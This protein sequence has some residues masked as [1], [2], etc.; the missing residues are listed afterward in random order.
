MPVF[1][2]VLDRWP[3]RWPSVGANPKVRIPLAVTRHDAV[4]SPAFEF[5]DWEFDTGFD[6]D[7]ASS[8]DELWKSHAVVAPNWNTN[9]TS[10]DALVRLNAQLTRDGPR[11]EGHAPG[12]QFA[13]GGVTGGTLKGS[14]AYRCRFWIRS[15]VDFLTDCVLPL[16]VGTGVIVH[17]GLGERRLTGMRLLTT[18][19]LA[20]EVDFSRPD[21][22]AIS[23][24]YPAEAIRRHH[25]TIDL[26][27]MQTRSHD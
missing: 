18:N 24:W 17:E 14:T 1:A 27:R 9:D 20:L 22:P 2:L 11:L 21:Q 12:L 7:A 26:S 19:F 8:P 4:A 15:N 3:I 6:G 23:I 13:L 10:S 5:H 25:P 16:E